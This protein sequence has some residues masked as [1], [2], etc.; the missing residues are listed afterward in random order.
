MCRRA[1]LIAMVGISI[2]AIWLVEAFASNV[3][4]LGGTLTCKGVRC[5]YEVSG[6]PGGTKLTTGTCQPDDIREA[7]LFCL[8][9]ANK[10]VGGSRQGEAFTQI[11]QFDLGLGIG[12]TTK[13]R[14]RS[15]YNLISNAEGTADADTDGDGIITD[16]ECDLSEACAVLRQF[17]V[18]PNWVPQ[19]VVPI[20][21]CAAMQ[22]WECASADVTE[23]PCDPTLLAGEPGACKDHDNNALNG[24]TPMMAGDKILFCTLPDPST[25]RFGEERVYDCRDAIPGECPSLSP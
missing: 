8:N 13:T 16:A 1:M 18:N 15:R 6:T 11:V 5:N 9:P 23:C 22:V 2:F 20:T 24:I 4:W 10:S 3:R 19:D 21:F 7:F 17:C 14:G 12:A 25:Y